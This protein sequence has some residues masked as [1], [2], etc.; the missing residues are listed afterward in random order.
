MAPLTH[1]PDAELDELR[2]YLGPAYDE[3]RL[4]GHTQAVLE[5]FA[6]APDEATHYRTSQ[7]YLYDLT[8][9]AM[10]PTKLP[11]LR[12]LTAA[13][14]PP[15]RLLDYGCGIG[16]DGLM[17]IEAGYDVAF[18]DFDN[19]SVAYLRW[20]LRQRGLEA[21]IYDLDREAPPA[22][23]DAV[24]SFDVIEHAEDPKAFLAALERC[25]G[26]VCVNFLDE[27]DGGIA[28]HHRLPIRRLLRHARRRGLVHQAC[29]HERSHLVLY[30]P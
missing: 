3:R 12:D 28:L 30:R 13:V 21:R 15:A 22:G 20:R 8:V 27:P 26:L 25:A 2:R 14:P 5:E 17:L 7:A 24:Y 4:R 23:H 18:A 10:S 19:P 11:Y 9:F 6:A 29:Y 16:S 1:N